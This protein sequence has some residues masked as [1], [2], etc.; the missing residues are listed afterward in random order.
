MVKFAQFFD[1]DHD[2]LAGRRSGKRKLN[3]IAV[4][5]T[6]KDQQA[7]LCLFEAERGVKLG[8]RA[9]FEPKL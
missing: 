8:L 4:L 7:V 3:K 9:G 1:N 2:I 6:V 5:K